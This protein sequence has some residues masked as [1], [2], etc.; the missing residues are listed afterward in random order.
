MEEVLMIPGKAPIKE[1][2]IDRVL[3]SA[4]VLSW[5]DLVKGSQT[6]I[7]D[8]EYGTAPEPSLQYLKIWLSTTRDTWDLICEY[9]IS[10]GTSPVPV[11]GLTFS[12]G[13]YSSDLK[14]MVG[15]LMRH[16]VSIPDLLSGKS[17]VT[18][19]RVQSPTEDD[20]LRA[21]TCMRDA[22]HRLGIVCPNIPDTAA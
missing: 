6:G 21:G 20:R 15:H 7:I 14:Q 13:Y 2:Q 19:M 5:N 10:P 9:W 22:Y 18:L 1:V 4:V 3:K 16:Q 12:N 17:S 8:I 11:A